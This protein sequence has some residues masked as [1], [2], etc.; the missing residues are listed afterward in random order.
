MDLISKIILL[1]NPEKYVYNSQALPVSHA[2][3][4]LPKVCQYAHVFLVD[5]NSP[6]L[7]NGIAS[8]RTY[9][10]KRK[11]PNAQIWQHVKS[12]LLFLVT[13]NALEEIKK[14]VAQKQ[15]KR[16]PPC[17][18]VKSDFWLSV[19]WDQFG[20]QKDDTGLHCCF[21]ADKQFIP[22]PWLSNISLRALCSVFTFIHFYFTFHRNI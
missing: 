5:K 1:S 11:K 15:G 14:R 8:H 2:Y 21:P 22:L 4:K 19:L 12:L 20:R 3:Y 7:Q 17:N 10:K 9:K 16:N 6:H 13:V 18:A